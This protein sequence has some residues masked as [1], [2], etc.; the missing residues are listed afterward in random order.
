M[1]ADRKSLVLRKGTQFTF[2]FRSVSSSLG[3]TDVSSDEVALTW[4]SE[5][6]LGSVQKLE[7]E[8]S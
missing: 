2:S 3:S 7:L 1:P 4:S 8:T 6:L 5:D